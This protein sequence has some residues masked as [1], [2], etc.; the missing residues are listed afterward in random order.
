MEEIREPVEELVD[1]LPLR[2]LSLSNASADFQPVNQVVKI[3]G[4]ITIS[5]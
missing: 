3:S 5:F 1:L 4:N 2:Y